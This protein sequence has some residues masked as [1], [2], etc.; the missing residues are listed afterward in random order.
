MKQV[1]S[2]NELRELILAGASTTELN[3]N[4]DYSGIT[5]MS[6]MFEN[7]STLKSH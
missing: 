5:D 7:S 4:Y 1:I 2:K 6:Q 3:D